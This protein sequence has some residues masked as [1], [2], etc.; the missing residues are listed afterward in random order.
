MIKFKV[1]LLVLILNSFLSC[2]TRK[3]EV[4]RTEYEKILNCYDNWNY[5]DL[6]QNDTLRVL[7]FQGCTSHSI[8][9]NPNLIIG[10]NAIGDTIGIIEKDFKG[11]LQKDTIIYVQPQ[12]WIEEQKKS[13]HLAFKMGANSYE[14]NLLCNVK[15]IYYCKII[16]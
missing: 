9:Y 7:Y 1:I 15:I 8:I 2:K 11:I 4:L 16:P 5:K 10:V 6:E 3:N 14:N 12:K 13:Y